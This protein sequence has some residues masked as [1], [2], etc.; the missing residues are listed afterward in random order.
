M[1][2]IIENLPD[3]VVGVEAFDEVNA[4]D[5]KNILIPALE[6]SV[7]KYN[8]IN[9]LLVLRTE[10]KNWTAGAWVQDMWAGMKN[11][12]KWNKIAVVTNESAVE[13]FT[14]GFSLLTPGEAKGFKLNEEE[15]AKHWVSSASN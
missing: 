14:D 6:R 4:D 7:N 12:T 15:E 3:N 13:K 2:K 5:L 8:E 1:L 10:V 9:Y 11:F